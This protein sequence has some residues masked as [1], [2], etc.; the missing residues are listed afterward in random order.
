[1]YKIV[2]PLCLVILGA[3]LCIAQGKNN[4]TERLRN[5]NAQFTEQI[6]KV[7]DNVYV[8]VGFSVS[9]VSM[10]VGDDGVVIIDTGMMLDD[11]ERIATEFRKITD[12]PVKA[13]VFT[14][15]ARRSHWRRG[16][17]SRR[18]TSADL[19]AREFWQRSSLMVVGRPDCSGF[20][21]R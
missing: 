2:V 4:A 10:I 17:V 7:A 8:A 11:A 3:N 9:N 16:G 13:I 6:V 18:R 21:G 20:T 14:H 15:C 12:K 1:M 19:G 5:Q